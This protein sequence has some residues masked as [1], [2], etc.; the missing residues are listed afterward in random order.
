YPH[1]TR[2]RPDAQRRV[3]GTAIRP[4]RVRSP[5]RGCSQH[6]ENRATVTHCVPRHLSALRHEGH[7]LQHEVTAR[8]TTHLFQLALVNMQI[9][10]KIPASGVEPEFA[11]LRIVRQLKPNLHIRL[12][13]VTPPCRG[14]PLGQQ[15]RASARLT[16]TLLVEER[17]PVTL[18]DLDAPHSPQDQASGNH[19]RAGDDNRQSVGLGNDFEVIFLRGLPLGDLTAKRVS[20]GSGNIRVTGG[21]APRGQAHRTAV[22]RLPRTNAAHHVVRE[23]HPLLRGSVR[24]SLE[25]ANLHCSSFTYSRSSSSSSSS[26]SRMPSNSAISSSMGVTP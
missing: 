24:V 4:S 9:G 13:A 23:R 2:P 15:L 26:S 5:L 7:L 11:E 12:G 16:V 21:D 6:S 8:G 22:N 14:F 3:P 19:I 18:V 1:D 25:N 20:H 17:D 10:K